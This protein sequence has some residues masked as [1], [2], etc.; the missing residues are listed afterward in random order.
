MKIT[1]FKRLDLCAHVEFM[2]KRTTQSR[3]API[4]EPL[5]TRIPKPIFSSPSIS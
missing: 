5:P 1:S 4:S 3:I 2:G